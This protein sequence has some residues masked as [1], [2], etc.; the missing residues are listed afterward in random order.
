MRRMRIHILGVCGTFMGGVAALARSAGHAVS[1]S[2]RNVYPPMSTQLAALGVPVLEGYAAER[3][4][5][6]T[7]ACEWSQRRTRAAGWLAGRRAR[8]APYSFSRSV[9]GA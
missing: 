3:A 7:A 2:D 5:R 8:P 9:P 1:G 6:R 4:A